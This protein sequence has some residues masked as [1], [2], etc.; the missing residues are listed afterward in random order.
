MRPI[1]FFKQAAIFTLIMFSS[2]GKQNDKKYSFSSSSADSRW[3]LIELEEVSHHVIFKEMNK[4]ASFPKLFIDPANDYLYTRFSVKEARSHWGGE[5]H[6][7]YMTMESRDGGISWQVIDELPLSARD[8]RP[9]LPGL[10]STGF[11]DKSLQG[12]VFRMKD[13]ALVRIGHYWR[14]WLPVERL[15][16]FE[17]KYDIVL[18]GENRGPGEDYFAILSGGYL[19]R[20]EDNGKTWE[21]TDIPELDTYVSCSSPWSYDQLPD[22]TVIRVFWLRESAEESDSSKLVAV[23]THDGKSA[24]VVDILGYIPGYQFT[25]EILLHVTSK[26]VIWALVRVRNFGKGTEHHNLWQLVSEDGG[27]SWTA[28]PS[29]IHIGFSPPSGLVQL[30]DGRL[31]LI[32]ADRAYYKPGIHA[33]ISEDEGLTWRHDRRIALRSDAQPR[34]VGIGSDMGY[35]EAVKLSDNTIVTVYYYYT[36][37]EYPEGG[38]LTRWICATRFKVP[39]FK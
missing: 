20:S 36:A 18:G 27:L 4:Y 32:A 15:P 1:N 2:C 24:R 33:L 37:E 30:D 31:V 8:S 17:G 22:G 19:E 6:E 35:P 39:E 26:G 5:T 38:E 11:N 23:M 28:A 12:G 3:P 10:L 14:R 13:R 29:P 9:L 34:Y 25:E 16:E 7:R 21:R